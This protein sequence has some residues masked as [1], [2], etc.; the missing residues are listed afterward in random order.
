[1]GIIREEFSKK[2]RAVHNCNYERIDAKV[3]GLKFFSKLEKS[4]RLEL[5]KNGS[6]AYYPAGTTIF[7][8]GDYGDLMYIIL[9]GTVNVRIMKQTIFG[10]IE[11]IIVA[12]LYDGSHFGEYA[13][14]GTSQQ[15]T[16]KKPA[17][18]VH[19]FFF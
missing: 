16:K 18:S 7:K 4:M 2:T 17:T 14:M 10:T 12:V 11:D 6:L 3:C 1:M 5:L 8:Q 13:M 19:F 15:N 9:R